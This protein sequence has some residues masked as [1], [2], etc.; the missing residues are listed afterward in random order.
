MIK[1]FIEVYKMENENT[2]THQ[3]VW[4]YTT[5]GTV[6]L[7]GLAVLTGF[8]VLIYSSIETSKISQKEKLSLNLKYDKALLKNIQ[9]LRQSNTSNYL[10]KAL[11][12]TNEEFLNRD[13]SVAER[14]LL[15]NHAAVR[16]NQ[17]NPLSST[18]VCFH[19]T[20]P[21]AVPL[22][23][24]LAL[25][26]HAR[27][28]HKNPIS[29]EKQLQLEINNNEAALKLPQTIKSANFPSQNHVRFQEHTKD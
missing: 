19:A 12:K 9:T 1:I 13:Q 11:S 25:D 6:I 22:G 20:T 15:K 23:S 27:T 21:D 7:A 24:G 10:N 17:I 29:F 2:T 28:Q 16:Y 4:N 3:N 26:V 14:I 8:G 5:V 18:E